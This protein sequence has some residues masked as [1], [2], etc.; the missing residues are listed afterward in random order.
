MSILSVAHP[1]DIPL[2]TRLRS[3]IYTAGLFLGPDNPFLWWYHA[4]KNPQADMTGPYFVLDAPFREVEP[5]RAVIASPEYM[6]GM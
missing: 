1:P 4:G 3:F 2:S 6:K 5:G